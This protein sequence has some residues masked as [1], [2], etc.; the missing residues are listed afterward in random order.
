MTGET[1]IAHRSAAAAKSIAAAAYTAAIAL[2]AAV[3]CTACICEYPDT[4][5][6]VQFPDGESI[7]IQVAMLDIADDPDDAHSD[8]E[9]MHDLRVIITHRES[10]GGKEHEVIEYNRLIDFGGGNGKYRYGYV[11]D[12]HLMFQIH[13]GTAVGKH[14]YLFANSEPIFERMISED[15][16]IQAVLDPEKD[17]AGQIDPEQGIYGGSR[18]EDVPQDLAD[19][20]L[21]AIREVTF[22]NAELQRFVADGTGLPM[23]AEYDI[24][25]SP[26][27]T[28]VANVHIMDA[29]IVRAA[30][31]ITFEYT[32]ERP[33]YPIFVQG[34]ELLSVAENAYLLPRVKENEAMF[35]KD[36]WIAWYAHHNA[37]HAHPDELDFEVPATGVSGFTGR[38]DGSKTYSDQ[39]S[40]GKVDSYEEK[41]A[42]L[43][44]EGMT[45][46]RPGGAESRP[47]EPVPGHTQDTTVYYFPETRYCP[48]GDDVQKYAIT[49]ETLGYTDLPSG[50]E[51]KHWNDGHSYPNRE[52]P[53]VGTLFRNTHVQVHAVFKERD[54]VELNV[55]IINWKVSD[56]V[57]GNLTPE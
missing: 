48:S 23:S 15:P 56:P 3:C 57:D 21:A 8:V 11:E 36:G 54:Q 32:N 10:I 40:T 41:V 20:Y 52:M 38:T 53:N 42:G 5:T 31:K 46:Q 51:G 47:A 28:G 1:N 7:A 6:R 33:P 13:D 29:Y 2:L 22:S 49:F 26:G 27:N 9:L 16:R 50:E 44:V 39:F 17:A 34:W 35:G 19:A 18:Y 55:S 25:F 12:P 4:G 37:S 43:Q 45:W 30:N 24:L 14:I